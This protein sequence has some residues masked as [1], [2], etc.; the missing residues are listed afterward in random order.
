MHPCAT[1]PCTHAHRCMRHASMQDAPLHSCTRSRLVEVS[2]HRRNTDQGSCVSPH[3]EWVLIDHRA[4]VPFLHRQD[5]EHAGRLSGGACLNDLQE[6]AGGESLCPP[7][8]GGP[9]AAALIG[10]KEVG[11]SSRAHECGLRWMRLRSGDD[12]GGG[13]DGG[14][15]AAS[16]HAG[17]RVIYFGRLRVEQERRASSPS[18]SCQ[19]SALSIAGLRLWW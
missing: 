3:A 4:E 19:C 8:H 10:S 14:E 6:G 7:D 17:C 18:G 5:R 16:I 15:G 1:H 13:S 2:V 9:Q 12:R 11:R